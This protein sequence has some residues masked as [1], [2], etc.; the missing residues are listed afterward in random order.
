MLKHTQKKLIKTPTCTFNVFNSSCFMY[1][2]AILEYNVFFLLLKMK[3]GGWVG[4]MGMGV[5]IKT[6]SEKGIFYQNKY[7][8]SNSVT[9]YCRLSQNQ[10]C[11]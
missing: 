5:D 1:S 6:N 7:I 2:F 8:F 4:L 9:G 11:T 3:L 10:F